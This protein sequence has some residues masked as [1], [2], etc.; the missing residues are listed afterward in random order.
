MSQSFI[1]KTDFSN[2]KLE[3]SDFLFIKGVSGQ[4][5]IVLGK[6]V[7]PISFSG[8]VYE[9]PVHVIKDL[10]HSFILGLDFMETNKVVVD[11]A[12][13]TLSIKSDSAKHLV[14]SIETNAGYARASK[15]FKVPSNSETV[16]EVKVSRRKTNDIVLLEP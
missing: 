4:K 16:L 9:F 13:N 12:T 6:L 5:R 10:N 3:S 7:L 11:F 8:H 14:C 2:S 15:I 1:S